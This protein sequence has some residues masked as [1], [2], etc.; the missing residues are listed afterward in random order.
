M[1]D[2]PNIRTGPMKK[3]HGDKILFMKASYNAI[4]DPFKAAAGQML[5]KEDRARQIEVGNEK[6]FKPGKHVRQPTNA[7]YEHMKEYEHLQKN[8]RDDE[9]KEVMIQPKNILTN[10][11]KNGR[12]GKNT[13]F[14]DPIP[15][16]EDDYNLPKKIATEERLH[17]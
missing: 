2:P 9:S 3:G 1:I 6:P 10:P 14:A 17:G 15:Y 7:T 11:P 4:G 12:V 16:M 13:Y 8:F 5:R